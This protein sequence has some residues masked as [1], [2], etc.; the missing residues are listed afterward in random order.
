MTVLDPPADI[1][2]IRRYLCNGLATLRAQS[3]KR[4][5]TGVSERFFKAMIPIGLWVVTNS[6]GKVLGTGFL[7]ANTNM[8]AGRMERNR[9]LVTRE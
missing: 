5:A 3:M 6:T 1:C 9:P 4:C 8:Q 7:L 2:M